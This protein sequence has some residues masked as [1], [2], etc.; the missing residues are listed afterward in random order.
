MSTEDK[1]ESEQD[2]DER[3][4]RAAADELQKQIDALVR[5][6]AKSLPEKPRSL[7]DFIEHSGGRPS[8][9]PQGPRDKSPDEASPHQVIESDAGAHDEEG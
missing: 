7:R 6:D 9:K 1:P 4:R 2:E 5:G 8:S 3:E